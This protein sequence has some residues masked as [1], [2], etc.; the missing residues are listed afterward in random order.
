M[1]QWLRQAIQELPKSYLDFFVFCTLTGL[2]ASETIE[3][4]RLLLNDDGHS[5]N[6]YYNS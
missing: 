4:V 6:Y 3:S 1:I 2:R 5:N